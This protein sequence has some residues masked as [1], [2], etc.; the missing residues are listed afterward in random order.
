MLLA[1]LEVGLGVLQIEAQVRERAIFACGTGC[2]A[3]MTAGGRVQQNSDSERMY[4]QGSGRGRE[5]CD[6]VN[7]CIPRAG[8]SDVDLRPRVPSRPAARQR[9]W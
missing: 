2:D 7:R 3:P 6:S 5:T 8:L 4:K 1:I 9:A